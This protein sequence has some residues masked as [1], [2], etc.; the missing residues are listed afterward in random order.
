MAIHQGTW[1]WLTREIMITCIPRGFCPSM[2]GYFYL[3]WVL[4]RSLLA[5]WMISLLIV[6]V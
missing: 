4:H 2:C 6:F 3:H 1:A 5:S